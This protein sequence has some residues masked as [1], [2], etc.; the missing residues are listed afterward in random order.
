MDM[1]IKTLRTLGHDVKI[2]NGDTFVII[3]HQKIQVNL[4]ER[5]SR[6]EYVNE[7]KYVTRTSAPT[8]HL[9]LRKG[10]RSWDKR[11]W[12]DGKVLLE[13]QLPKII[14]DLVEIANEQ[15]QEHERTIRA[16]EE[17]KLE[18][19]V[20][21]ESESK[22]R[23]ELHRFKQLLLEAHQFSVA[24]MV[25]SYV[26]QI[27]LVGSNDGKLTE[28]TTQWIIWA[29]KKADWFDPSIPKVTD[30]LLS[31]ID[32]ENLKSRNSSFGGHYSNSREDEHT[33]NHFWKPWWSK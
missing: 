23:A 31:G 28:E 20:K 32:I 29:R 1:L 14:A 15:K 19:R 7:Y 2:E 9:Y 25:R 24:N 33:K 30:D 26:D 21:Q 4:S 10:N 11:E 8:G 18:A 27:E 3:D 12:K 5:N 22:Q 16:E 13:D 6:A 17:R